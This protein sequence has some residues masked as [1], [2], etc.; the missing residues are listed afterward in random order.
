MKSTREDTEALR[1]ERKE[2][3]TKAEDLPPM[4]DVIEVPATVDD[5]IP[6]ETEICEA[7]GRLKNGKAPGP[8]GIT[9]EHLKKWATNRRTEP[10]QWELVTKVVEEA[11]RT[12]RIPKRL[13]QSICVLIPKNEKG[14]YRGIGLLETIWKLIASII[15]RWLGSGI[16]LHDAHHGFQ[17]G[18]GT[19][20]AIMETKL[21]MQMARRQGW[22]YYQIFLDLSKAYDTIDRDRLI[23]ILKKYGVG[24]RIIRLLTTFWDNQEVATK[25]TSFYGE[26]FQA[27]R[28][29]TQG[30]TVSPTLFNIAVDAVI[31]AWERE[32]D[33]EQ[34]R[35]EENQ[36]TD[37]D[38][39]FYADDGKVGSR[40]PELVQKSVDILT[41]LF[42][43]LGLQMNA[44]KT[45]A[46]VTRGVVETVKQST[47]AYRRRMGQGGGTHREREAEYVECPM[48]KQW[49]QRKSLR[50]H[51]QHLHTK[52][53]RAA[54]EQEQELEEEAEGVFECVMGTGNGERAPC[55]IPGCGVNI[56]RR[57]GMR[58]HFMYRHPYA[59]VYFPGE[60]PLQ[61]CQECGMKVPKLAEHKGNR[62]CRKAQ[63]RRENGQWRRRTGPQTR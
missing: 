27:T 9:A 29:V 35:S 18:R 54:E 60:A 23:H 26:P 49:M 45:K 40:D 50:Q 34:E 7:I 13:S 20:T 36:R 37:V 12:G 15:D 42:Q 63:E 1:K 48:C 47:E 4:F 31:R 61:E 43:C 44:K 5:S 16:T 19:G 52:Q 24:P 6:T 38:C 59:A 32:M 58:R 25:Q 14:D 3:Y 22:P 17:R 39:E 10:K 57:Y 30:D 46:M 41:D 62:L 28:G 51:L 56:T 11:F 53:A 8:S 2:L 33:Q 21:Q 55:P